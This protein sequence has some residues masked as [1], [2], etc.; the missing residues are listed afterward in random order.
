MASAKSEMIRIDASELKNDLQGLV[1]GTVEDTLNGL[2]DK[3]AEMICKAGR[4]QRSD[5]RQAQRNGKYESKLVTQAGEVKLQVP[6]LRGASFETQIIERY[7]RRESSVEESLVEMYLAGVSVRRVED[8]TEALWGER[9]SPSSISRLNEKIYEQIEDW[10]TRPL[11]ESYPYVFMDG[12]WLKRSWGGQVENISVLIAVGVNEQGRREVIGVSEGL[13]ESTESWKQL[14]QSL[15]QRGVKSMRLVVSDAGAGLKSALPEVYPHAK[16]QR[17]VFHFHRNIL[18]AVPR[19]KREEVAVRLKAIHAMESAAASLEKARLII[20]WLREQKLSKAAR[21]LEKGIEET[22]EYHR[23][24]REH[25]RSLRTN[26]MLERIMKEIRRRTRV[27]G[28][29]PD[30]K[31]ALM[32]VCAR[33]RHISSKSW[34]EERSYLDMARLREIDVEDEHKSID[35]ENLTNLNK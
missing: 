22:L 11:E 18:D 14:L 30:G 6:K 32:L 35:Q 13:K 1:R 31:S 10:R 7:R 17:C 23:F 5:S 26:N 3:E 12:I 27:V 34:P 20:A 16:Q 33:L 19:A 4:Y 9:V 21:I 15:W 8:I 28:S 24:P 25:H 2:L 29:F